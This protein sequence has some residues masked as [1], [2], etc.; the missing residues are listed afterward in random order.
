MR[1]FIGNSKHPD[2]VTHPTG[3]GELH[4]QLILALAGAGENVSFPECRVAVARAKSCTTAADR[5]TL[6]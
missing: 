2:R 6:P 4:R 3:Y 5:S 1:I